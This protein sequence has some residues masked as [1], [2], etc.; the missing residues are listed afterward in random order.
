MATTTQSPVSVPQESALTD[1]LGWIKPDHASALTKELKA[2]LKCI[3]DNPAR[4]LAL[5]EYGAIC[6]SDLDPDSCV[7]VD[8]SLI[9]E[10]LRDF[11]TLVVNTNFKINGKENDWSV[12]F[13]GNRWLDMNARSYGVDY[14]RVAF[15]SKKHYKNPTAWSS[16]K[17]YHITITIEKA[18][19]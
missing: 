6:G 14:I 9:Q 11:I 13:L 8:K 16:D 3:S 7:P 19:R 15:Y 4:F 2:Y 18:R 1:A 5:T 12:G 10:V 17:P